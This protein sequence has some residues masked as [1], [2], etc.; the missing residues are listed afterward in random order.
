MKKSEL[1]ENFLS[2]LNIDIDILNYID[3]DNVTDY[4]SLLDELEERNAFE[5]SGEVIY[6]YNAIKYLMD[7]DDSLNESLGL[8]SE[9]GYTPDNLNSEI[10]ATLLKTQNLREEFWELENEITDF[11]EELELKEFDENDEE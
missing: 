4:N 8:A 11:F 3:I 9:L 1:I 10:L 5:Q 2:N 7:Y 6:Y